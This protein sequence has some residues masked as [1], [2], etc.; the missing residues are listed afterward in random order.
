MDYDDGEMINEECPNCS[1]KSTHFEVAFRYW[2]CED[3]SNVWAVGQ[4]KTY[5]D[6]KRKYHETNPDTHGD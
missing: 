1:G 5:F 6:P 3:C 4:N 2:K